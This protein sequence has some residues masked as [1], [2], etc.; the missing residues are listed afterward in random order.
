MTC[1]LH[2]DVT[3]GRQLGRVRTDLRIRTVWFSPVPVDAAVWVLLERLRHQTRL[4]GLSAYF[5]R[6]DH[7]LTSLERRP[8]ANVANA[9]ITTTGVS[10]TS[11]TVRL[12]R[13]P[14]RGASHSPAEI[15]D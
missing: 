9:N 2:H 8:N 12:P 15:L 5:G 11:S 14:R 7:L 3:T 4:C 10:T 13:S 6:F 1:H